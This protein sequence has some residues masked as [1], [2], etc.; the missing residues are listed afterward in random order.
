M[1]EEDEDHS[2]EAAGDGGKGERLF[3]RNLRGILFSSPI[4][5][6]RAALGPQSWLGKRGGE[7]L[8]NLASGGRRCHSLSGE[9][10][11]WGRR[12]RWAEK[13]ERVRWRA[14]T[15]RGGESNPG[16]MGVG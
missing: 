13:R 2:P 12:R 8:I 16:K 4:V 1:G 7:D 15:E 11:H 9:E 3:A 10:N 6:F 5:D 14:E